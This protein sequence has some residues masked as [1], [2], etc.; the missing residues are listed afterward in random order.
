[1]HAGRTSAWSKR[2]DA[3]DPREA[4]AARAVTR[5]QRLTF[6]LRARAARPGRI[7]THSRFRDPA[8]FLPLDRPIP[9]SYT[10][11]AWRPTTASPVRVS[12]GLP[13]S[14]TACSRLR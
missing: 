8:A 6:G 4:I 7:S 13:H 9:A 5:Q 11:A 12:S 10:H 14:A 2:H 1:G 3:E